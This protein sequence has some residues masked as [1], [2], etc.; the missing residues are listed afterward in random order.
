MNRR[1][2]M[3]LDNIRN[4]YVAEAMEPAKRGGAIRWMALAASLVLV[5]GLGVAL[6]AWYQNR[7]VLPP[8]RQTALENSMS[9]AEQYTFETAVEAA[10]IVA[11]VR[12][13][14][15][16]GDSSSGFVTYY[17]AEVLQTFK[18]EV[19]D[20]IVIQQD[21]SS[22]STMMGY[23]LFAHGNEFLVFLN[24]TTIGDRTDNCYWIIGSWTTV[25]DVVVDD[26]ENYYIIDRMDFWKN[27]PAGNS[28]AAIGDEGKLAEIEAN[29]L[30]KDPYWADKGMNFED[31][32]YLKL[33]ALDKL[34]S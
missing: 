18:G 16:L 1:V 2:E 7:V 3:I 5:I 4:E 10:P 30:E 24:R 34:F 28:V 32:A 26:D 22:K 11:W 14:N 6:G 20:R 12:I 15:W 27:S 25:F 21:G 31:C 9:L 23:P 33:E 13:G 29:F 19:P 8:C 17:E